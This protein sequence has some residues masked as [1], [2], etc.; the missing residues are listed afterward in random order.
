MDDDRVKPLLL[1]QAEIRGARGWNSED[2]EG[3]IAVLLSQ[4]DALEAAL[5][6]MIYETTHLSPEECDGSHWCKISKDALTSARSAR[7][8]EQH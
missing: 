6:R 7:E 5:D 3:L 8:T 2:A 4:R 1:A